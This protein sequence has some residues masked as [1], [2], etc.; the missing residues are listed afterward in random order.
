MA[1]GEAVDSFVNPKWGESIQVESVQELALNVDP[2]VV[3]PRYI[4]PWEERPTSS[5]LIS[6]E[7]A[8]LLI[9]MK[10]L[11]LHPEDYQRQQEMERLSNACQE[12]GFFHVGNY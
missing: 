5:L 12:W 4:R 7:S 1:G 9:D 2:Q 6:P 3:P 10:K 8:I 11:I